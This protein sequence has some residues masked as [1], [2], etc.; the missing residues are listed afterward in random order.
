MVTKSDSASPLGSGTPSGSG[1]STSALQNRPAVMP[2]SLAALELTKNGTHGYHISRTVQLSMGGTT[3]E[4]PS[5][6]P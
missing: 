4:K 6:L 1:T 2:E 3:D 5:F